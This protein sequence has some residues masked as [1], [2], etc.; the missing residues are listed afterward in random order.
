VIVDIP[1]VIN[2]YERIKEEWISLVD[3]RISYSKLLD[4]SGFLFYWAVDI[5]LFDSFV[6]VKNHFSP[7]VIGAHQ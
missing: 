1:A 4:A 7:H 3:D 2:N 6:L 5:T